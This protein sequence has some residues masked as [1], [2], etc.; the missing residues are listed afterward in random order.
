MT[1]PARAP[2]VGDMVHYLD[3]HESIAGK[4]V[5]RAAIV[6]QL[7]GPAED[8]LTREPAGAWDVDLMVVMPRKL[9]AKEH[10]VQ[11]DTGH[12]SSGFWHW[13]TEHP[14]ALA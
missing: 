11:D 4:R 3:Q 14:P 6:S 9:V 2:L 7:H 5:C 1:W 13:P 8:S 10:V 12:G